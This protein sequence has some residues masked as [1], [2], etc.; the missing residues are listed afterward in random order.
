LIYDPPGREVWRVFLWGFLGRGKGPN[1]QRV[2]DLRTA[3]W[4]KGP[5][6]S[7]QGAARNEQALGFVT[8]R[9]HSQGRALKERRK[10][11]ERVCTVHR[12]IARRPRSPAPIQG[13]T[14]SKAVDVRG[15]QGSTR[16]GSAR[17]GLSPSRRW[18]GSR[19]A[20]L[21]GMESVLG[22]VG[23]TGILGIAG[24]VG[25]AGLACQR[26]AGVSPGRREERASPGFCDDAPPLP[27][28]RSEGARER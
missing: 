24:M 3:L 12:C 22:I 17:P 5:Q 27:R 6:E 8:T 23:L 15:S 18:R 7:A 9:R 10:G 26:S 14:L 19:S 28:A 1:E 13:A 21:R 11:G 20:R 16:Q 2:T 25:F 4:A